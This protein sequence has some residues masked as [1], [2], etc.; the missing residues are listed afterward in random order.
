MRTTLTLDDQVD[1]RLRKIAR[2]QNRSYKEIVNEAIAHGLHALESAEPASEYHVRARHFGLKP[3]VDRA[4]LNQ[5]YD[6]LE[7]GE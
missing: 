6:E 7:A 3:G 5:L 4:K 2:E 1:A